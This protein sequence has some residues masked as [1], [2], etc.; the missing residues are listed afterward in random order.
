VSR[1]TR[2]IGVR[3]AIGASRGRVLLDVVRRAAG[4]V[5]IGIVIGLL[6]SFVAGRLLQSQL[7]GTSGR[8]PMVL[9]GGTVLLVLSALAAALIPARRA[10]SLDPI[11]ALRNE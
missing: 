10:A 3:M 1:R 7:F 6:A 5:A 9:A 4:Q 2:E 11:K 8:D